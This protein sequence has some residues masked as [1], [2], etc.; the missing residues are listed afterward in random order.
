MET[1]TNL[2]KSTFSELNDNGLRDKIFKVTKAILKKV[3]EDYFSGYRVSNN[4]QNF[5]YL[6]S[7]V[8]SQI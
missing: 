2:D 1:K 6:H 4:E 8:G 7:E 5:G 3:E